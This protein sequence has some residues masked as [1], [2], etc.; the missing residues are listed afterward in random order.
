MKMKMK[1]KKVLFTFTFVSALVLFFTS[2]V[3][4]VIVAVNTS[5]PTYYGLSSDIKPL[6]N[7][8]GAYFYETNTNK[9]FVWAISKAGVLADWKEFYLPT[10]KA[11]RDAGE[12]IVGSLI[13][14]DYSSTS[15]ETRCDVVDTSVDTTT[16]YPGPAILSYVYVN[17]ALSALTVLISDGATTK[18]TLPASLAAGP[19]TAM[20]PPGAQFRTSLI[21]DPDNA[22]TGNITV[23]FRPLSGTTTW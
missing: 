18:F 14:S 1:M 3:Q 2:S 21:V 8:A 6:N 10:Y 12:R 17:T 13:G 11:S 23:C 7:I 15:Q 9:M 19:T 5:P 16:V 22:S 20:T 4:A